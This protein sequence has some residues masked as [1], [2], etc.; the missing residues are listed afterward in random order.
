MFSA[1]Y[2]SDLMPMKTLARTQIATDIA[3]SLSVSCIGTGVQ[4]F[5][6]GAIFAWAESWV[7][8]RFVRSAVHMDCSGTSG[9]RET[10]MKRP[11]DA[12][13]DMVGTGRLELPT[14]RV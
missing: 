9:N 3:A 14:S 4:W 12:E 5:A 10:A 6:S 8:T 11:G 2:T 7:P 13:G 1:S